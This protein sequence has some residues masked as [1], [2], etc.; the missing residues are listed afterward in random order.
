[1]I[2]ITICIY[3][4]LTFFI[5]SIILYWNSVHKDIIKRGSCKKILKDVTC[6]EIIKE[7]YVKKKKNQKRLRVKRDYVKR[8]KSLNKLK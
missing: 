6:K 3:K 7:I 4:I 8:K 5:F 1:M 2:L